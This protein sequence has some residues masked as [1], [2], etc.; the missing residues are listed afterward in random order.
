MQ[1]YSKTKGA[2]GENEDWWTLH[3]NKVV[4]TWH[5]MNPYNSTVSSEGVKEFSI[6]ELLALDSDGRAKSAL[7]EVLEK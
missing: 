5:H 1:F 7:R 4:H 6:E 2:L 3:D